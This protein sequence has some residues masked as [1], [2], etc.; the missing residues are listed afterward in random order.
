M[1]GVVAVGFFT[2]GRGTT[3]I[4]TVVLRIASGTSMTSGATSG[5][6]TAHDTFVEVLS[7]ALYYKEK[8]GP[9]KVDIMD[10]GVT[11]GYIIPDYK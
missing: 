5:L 9:L 1:V 7:S 10:L 11:E 3:T 4:G 6:P 2:A 8:R